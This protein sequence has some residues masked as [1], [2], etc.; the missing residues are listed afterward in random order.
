MRLHRL[1]TLLVAL[2]MAGCSSGTKNLCERTCSYIA[3]CMGVAEGS[4]SCPLSASCGTNDSCDAD[5][6]QFATC[7]AITGKDAAG[8]ATLSSCRAACAAAPNDAGPR[9]DGQPG[10]WEST[11]YFPQDV[12]KDVDILF[13]MDNSNSMAEE[14]QNLSQNFP[15]FI[16]ALRTPKLNN[17]IPNV[18]I[19]VVTADLGAGNYGLPSC[20]TTGGDGGKLQS[21]ARIAGCVPP[22]DPYISYIDGVTNVKS[23]T[24]DA[25]QQVKE[26]FQCIVEIGTGGCGFEQTLE[27][28]RRALDQTA[29]VNPGFIRKDASLAVVIITDEDDCSASK[30]ALYDPGDN[31][32]GPL[33]SFRCFQHGFT[34]DQT[35]LVA[36]GTKTGC[37]PGQQ[38]L[39]PTDSYVQF[40]KG[41]KAPGRVLMMAIAGPTDKVSVGLDAQNPVLKPSCQTSQGKA[42]PGLRIEHVVDAFGGT[43][44]YNQ[45]VTS[46]GQLINVNICSSDYSPAL[47]L[48][49]HQVT[50]TVMGLGAQCL[51]NPPLT[52]SGGVVCQAGDAIGGSVTCKQSCLVKAD[53]A[54]EESVNQGTATKVPKCDESKFTNPADTSCGT[55]CPCWRIVPNADCTLAG[56]TP[57]RFE[58]LRKGDAAKGTTAK[59]SCRTTP[60]KWGSVDLAALPQCN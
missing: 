47:R 56:G 58:I 60:H 52:P 45:G 32:L 17:K 34:C 16:E 11:W 41:L 28:T 27:S 53:C 15:L 29:N 38:W 26:A 18:H 43:G 10:Y 37:K 7:E 50:G 3:Q 48:L 22:T 5:C 6:Y 25:V 31:A 14:Q 44:H 8:A 23:S 36:S 2:A 4:W 30:P 42:V 21:Q 1:F 49:A 51:A 39:H 59:V 57:Y 24:S 20:E 13:V 12:S 54:V 40:F 19:G 35:D 46:D 9:H 33:T 55:S